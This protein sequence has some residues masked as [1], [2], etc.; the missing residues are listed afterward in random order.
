MPAEVPAAWAFGGTRAQAAKL[1]ELVLAGAKTGTASALWDFEA[2]EDPLP[3]VG[4]VNIIVDGD[5]APRAVVQT[6]DIRTMPFHE[7]DEEHAASEGEG[8]LSLAHWRA[9]HAEF[10]EEYSTSGFSPEMPVVCERFRV[11][12]SEAERP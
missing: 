5:G 7:V 11:V 2:D 3:E 12:Y 4:E 9:V 1:L 8:D 10:W 6:T